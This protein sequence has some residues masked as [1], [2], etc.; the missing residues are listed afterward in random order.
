MKN[1][2]SWQFSAPLVNVDLPRI[3]D[4][5]GDHVEALGAVKVV[6]ELGRGER[7]SMVLADSDLAARALPRGVGIPDGFLSRETAV[8]RHPSGLVVGPGI[9]SRSAEA[10]ELVLSGRGIAIFRCDDEAAADVLIGKLVDR[11]VVRVEVF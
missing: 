10:I 11:V 4:E 8:A 1:V 6:V 7:V 5:A 2:S 9:P 3:L